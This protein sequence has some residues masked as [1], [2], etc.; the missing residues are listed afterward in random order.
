MFGSNIALN[1][2]NKIGSRKL[3]APGFIKTFMIQIIFAVLYRRILKLHEEEKNHDS[4]LNSVL[5][6]LENAN[7]INMTLLSRWLAA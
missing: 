7:T 1:N 4:W 6:G 5:S 3:Q 2:S